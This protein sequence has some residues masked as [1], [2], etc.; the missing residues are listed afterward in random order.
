MS[1][2]LF[3]AWR[4]VLHHRLQTAL[5][6]ACVT[7]TVGLPLAVQ[8]LVQRYSEQ[9]MARAHSTPL[10]AGARGSRYDL[11]LHALYFRGAAPPGLQAG[12][13]KRLREEEL[14][15]AIP[16]YAR[17]TAQGAPLVGTSLDY[18]YFR[19]LE[20]AAGHLPLRLGD[21]VVGAAA[22]RRLGVQPGGALLTD[23]ENVLDLAGAYP[24]KLRVTGVLAPSGSPDDDAVFAD[25]RTVWIAQGLGHG[26][27]DVVKNAE[28]GTILK[29][30]DGNVVA[31][32]ALTAYTEIT[33]ANIASF[34]FHGDE[35]TFPLGAVLVVPPDAK[36]AALLR[37]RYERHE[38]VQLRV[39]VAEIEGLLG[40][41][42]K[43]K[44]FFDA[45][46]ALVALA[47]AGFLALTVWLSLR[48]RA[49]ERET[50]FRLGCRRGTV[51][52][53]MAA[54]LGIIFVLSLT[55]AALAAGLMVALEAPLTRWLLS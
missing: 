40:L 38:R 16:L 48:L 22:A 6:V 7:L 19:G 21:C 12:D 25:L 32:A 15:L 31:N 35:D 42:F 23:P 20:T 10:V 3:L 24:L 17:F 28:P 30:E 44:R 11:V 27:T 50:L 18:F 41:V 36:A 2:P 45:N 26:H 51:A 14:G 54:E 53:A 55:L 43:A 46:F 33:E 52:L 1:G 13:A 8:M 29:R 9:L 34:H 47:T 39:P 37:G 5:L 4:Y 49:R